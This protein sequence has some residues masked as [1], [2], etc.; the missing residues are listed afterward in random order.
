MDNNAS[1]GLLKTVRGKKKASVDVVLQKLER[2][3]G[4]PFST[5]AGQIYNMAG[6]FS[7][8]FEGVWRMDYCFLITI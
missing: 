5:K 4:N 3:N 7:N 6:I 8:L 1:N 2:E